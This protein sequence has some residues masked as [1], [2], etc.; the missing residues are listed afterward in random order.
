MQL[1]I[2]GIGGSVSEERQGD[3]AGTGTESAGT[4]MESSRQAQ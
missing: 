4:G 3:G 2:V 1:H